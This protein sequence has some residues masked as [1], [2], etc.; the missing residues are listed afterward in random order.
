MTVVPSLKEIFPKINHSSGVFFVGSCFSQVL[1][2]KWK[3]SKGST[4]YNPFGTVYNPVSIRKMIEN[5]IHCQI[6]APESISEH[7][8]I[9]F[10]TD[11]HSDMSALSRDEVYENIRQTTT[12]ATDFLPNATYVFITLGTAFVYE[13]KS[14]GQIVANCHKLPASHFRKRMLSTEEII[15]NLQN[16]LETIFAINSA[17]K[18]VWTVSP[19]RHIKDGI[20]ENNW[21]KARLV[22]A[23]HTVVR[24]QKNMHYFPA[25]ELVLDQMRDYRYYENDLI[26]PGPEAREAIWQYFSDTYFDDETRKLNVDIQKIRSAF[27]HRPKFPQHADYKRF[28]EQQLKAIQSALKRYPDLDFTEEKNHFNRFIYS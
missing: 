8:G 20:I 1:G 5:I 18:V 7:N 24:E 22:D 28:C 16:I 12:K 14:S 10:H 9:Y 3:E 2:A 4:L 11:Y 15:L 23:V 27:H 26:H 21:S 19:V 17:T 25:Y 6:P 13:E